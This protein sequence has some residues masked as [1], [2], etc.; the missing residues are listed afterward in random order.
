MKPKPRISLPMKKPGK[1]DKLEPQWRFAIGYFLLT[2]LVM[3]V[4]QEFFT[5]ASVRTIPYSEFKKYLARHE[6][7]EAVVKQDQI[8]G[9]I[10][11][12][13]ESGPQSAAER[14]A[15]VASG[16]GRQKAP[17]ETKPF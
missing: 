12:R 11:P 15:S 6:V 17:T 2:L 13:A 9:R 4:W 14:G 10:V 16:H 3:W 5:A 7:A 8:D 1:V